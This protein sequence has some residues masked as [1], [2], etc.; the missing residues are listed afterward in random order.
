MRR[1]RRAGQPELV[2]A[3]S[4]DRVNLSSICNNVSWTEKHETRRNEVSRAT[5]R[6]APAGGSD[7]GAPKR[8]RSRSLWARELSFFH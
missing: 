7:R 6:C 3:R 5:E 4:A 8:S 2:L 1:S